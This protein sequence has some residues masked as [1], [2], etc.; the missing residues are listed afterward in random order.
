MNCLLCRLGSVVLIAWTATSLPADEPVLGRMKL[1]QG[2]ATFGVALPAGAAKEGVLVGELPTQNDVKNRWPDG[3]IRFVVVTAPPSQDSTYALTAGAS[4]LQLTPPNAQQSLQVKFKIGGVEYVANSFR[5]HSQDRWLDGPLVRE[6]RRIVAPASAAGELHPRLRV[7][8]DLRTYSDGQTRL[9]VTV[10]HTIDHEGADRLEYS[11]DLSIDGNSLFRRE[12]IQHHFMTR[13]RL[14]LAL[15]LVES[16][17]IHDFE[18][19]QKAGALPRFLSEVNND[20][21]AFNDPRFDILGRGLLNPNMPEH[22]GRAELAP[23]PDWTARYIAL[24]HPTAKLATI[25]HGDL[26]GS[27]PIH[28]REPDGRMISIDERPG[29]W[30]DGR[31]RSERPDGPRFK[32]PDG[33]PAIPDSKTLPHKPDVAHQPSLAYV[34]YL[35]TGD[36]YYADEMAFWANYVL[37]ATW[38]GGRTRRQDGNIFGNEVRGIA[39]GLRNLVDAATYIPD[40]DPWKKYFTQKVVANLEFADRYATS[41]KT[42]L[43]TYFD[44]NSWEPDFPNVWT[45]DRPWQLNYLAWSLAHA[46]DQGFVPGGK[47]RDG[48][49]A[50]QV[51]LFSS[52]P[53]YPIEYGAPYRLLVG[54]TAADGTPLYYGTLGEML[55]ATW[56]VKD[57]KRKPHDPMPTDWGAAARSTLVLAMDRGSQEA[58]IAYGY[59]HPKVAAFLAGHPGFAIAPVGAAPRADH[60]GPKASE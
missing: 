10:E 22:G 6:S 29:F 27:W 42:P 3:S 47:L 23:Y 26:A 5:E 43:G 21:Y 32:L 35:A 44:G 55:D 25:I 51:K 56:P 53:E 2:W 45:I 31:E 24:Q 39:W 48:L 16:T 12:N 37:L 14:P 20:R 9:D 52:A 58:V 34:P 50:F 59:F 13:W 17:V 19:F 7:I 36:R 1:S 11:V 33:G 30:L 54:K 46:Q 40:A 8:F 41:H 28:L 18:S 60:S 4:D 57:G 38:P 15:G 49:L